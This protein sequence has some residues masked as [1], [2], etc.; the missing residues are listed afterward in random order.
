M[1]SITR[2]I[3]PDSLQELTFDESR[4]KHRMEGHTLS[5]YAYKA[6]NLKLFEC[7]RLDGTTEE[8]R[9][10]LLDMTEKSSPTLSLSSSLHSE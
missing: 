3:H 5:Q 1:D 10:A 8:N 4:E 6:A 9:V 7:S 2:H